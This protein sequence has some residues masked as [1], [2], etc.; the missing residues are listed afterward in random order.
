MAFCGSC[1]TQVQDGTRFCPVCG[2]DLAAAPVAPP[3]EQQY[4]PVAPPVQAPPPVQ[5]QWQAPPQVQAPPP[6]PVQVAPPPPVQVA[7]PAPPQFQQAPP[8][9]PPV[10]QQWQQAPPPPPPAQQQWQQAPQQ[11]YGQQPYP[12]Q[13]YPQQPP[14][15]D[16]E[17]NK[18]MAILSYLIFFVP[19]IAGTHKTSPFV[20]FHVNQGTVLVIFSVA[21]SI[22]TAILS[23]IF[24]ALLFAA[25]AY[26]IIALVTGLFTLIGFAPLVLVIIGIINASKGVMKQ[27]PI[28]GKFNIIK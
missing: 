14:Q 18:G 23:A 9:P 17:A 12:Q 21:L 1:G 8:P 27:L 6:P 4:Q 19:L 7:P 25:R 26:G 24:S 20:K 15:N 5:E 22:A 13:P 16:A 28:I 2:N 3:Q 11:P 10:Q